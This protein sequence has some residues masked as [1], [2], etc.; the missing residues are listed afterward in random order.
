[1]L[2]KVVKK[3]ATFPQYIDI[4]YLEVIKEGIRKTKES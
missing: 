4:K 3:E 1:M 2:N